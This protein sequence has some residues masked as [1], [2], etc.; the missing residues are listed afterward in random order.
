MVRPRMVIKNDNL[1]KRSVSIFMVAALLSGCSIDNYEK[2]SLQLTGKIIDSE[3]KELVESGGINAGTVVKTYEG[4]SEQ[5]LMLTTFPDGNFVNS[6]MFPAEYRLVAEGPFT[7]V[8]AEQP[9][10]LS[11]NENVDIE[12]MPNMR[13]KSTLVSSSATFATVKISYQKVN[14]QQK[15]AALGITWSTSPNPNMLVF[16]HGKTILDDVSAD[17][18][19]DSGERTYQLTGLSPK[20]TYYIRAAAR[21]VNPG[22]YY[23]YSPQ[24]VL[25]TE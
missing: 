11:K 17:K 6:K 1:M 12:V 21:T 23:N 13:V 24:L 25:K 22:N 5:P 15:A 4:S 14:A 8:R 2:P 19:P 9:V 10:S 18:I 16:P 3:S 20:T 7:L